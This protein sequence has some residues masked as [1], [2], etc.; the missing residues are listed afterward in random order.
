MEREPG[1]KKEREEESADT[2]IFQQILSIIAVEQVL[3]L[4]K[5][6]FFFIKSEF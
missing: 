2:R 6:L 4:W 5:S 1:R 3:L